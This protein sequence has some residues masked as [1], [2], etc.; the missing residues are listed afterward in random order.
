MLRLF[1]PRAAGGGGV[2]LSVWLD[3]NGMREE[4]T[5]FVN[6]SGGGSGGEES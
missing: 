4:V 5:L 3:R 2:K 1:F 6:V